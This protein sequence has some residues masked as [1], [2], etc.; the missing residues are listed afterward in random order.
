MDAIHF[1]QYYGTRQGPGC[2]AEMVAVEVLGEEAEGL[3]DIDMDGVEAVLRLEVLDDDADSVILKL[4]D[5]ARLCD[6]V[7]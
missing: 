5:W 2:V 7:D 4:R 1:N 6:A 3:K